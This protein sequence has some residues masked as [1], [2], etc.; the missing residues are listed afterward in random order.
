MDMLE[1]AITQVPLRPEEARRCEVCGRI[2]RKDLTVFHNG[3]WMCIDCYQKA[4][5]R[6]GKRTM[7][8][9]LAVARL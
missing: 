8:V 2:V 6:S 7:A 1:C 4:L 3:K 9:E 5:R